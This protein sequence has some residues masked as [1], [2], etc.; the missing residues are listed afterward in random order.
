MFKHTIILLLAIFSLSAVAQ[1][2]NI[3][4]E[5]KCKNN[6]QPVCGIDG[7]TFV[8]A[9]F[10]DVAGIEIDYNTVCKD[11][12]LLC[13]KEYEPVCGADKVTYDNACLAVSAGV[14]IIEPIACIGHIAYQNKYAPVC[15]L[16][17]ETYRNRREAETDN[18]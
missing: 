1:N 15:G 3:T 7:N 9:C 10:A 14:E 6:F 4:S 2:E 13:P 18:M 5:L 8:N 11:P 16:I 17:G 12:S